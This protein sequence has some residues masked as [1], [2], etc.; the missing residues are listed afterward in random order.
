M[1][2]VEVGARR[3][4]V[5][6]PERFEELDPRD[7]SLDGLFLTIAK[8]YPE[9]APLVEDATKQ[10]DLDIFVNN[11]PVADAAAQGLRLRDGDS[12]RLFFKD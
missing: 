9:L 8:H 7:G 12:V 11:R 2:R 5:N 3:A 4:H 1:I 10:D 6:G